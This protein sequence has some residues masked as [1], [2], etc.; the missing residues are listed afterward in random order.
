[1]DNPARIPVICDRCRAEGE[2][3]FAPFAE[4]L[5][6]LHFTPVPRRNR[7]GGWDEQRQRG[8]IA[9]LAI[10]GSPARAARAVGRAGFGADRL[11]TAKGSRSFAAAWD[12]AL[13]IFHERE[14]FR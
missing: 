13:D 5:D 8:F 4:I 11:K 1:M 7:A 12:A 9:A 3:G 14:A 10:T 2:A 6:L